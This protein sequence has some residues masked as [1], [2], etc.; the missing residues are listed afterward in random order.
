MAAGWRREPAPADPA[1]W[2]WAREPAAPDPTAS[3]WTWKPAETRDPVMSVL[4]SAPVPDEHPLPSVDPKHPRLE[5][6]LAV[7]APRWV[8]RRQAAR[9]ARYQHAVWNRITAANDARHRATD[10]PSRF[11]PSWRGSRFWHR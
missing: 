1:A 11:G 3:R 6:F 4:V 7:V 8:A 9:V 5:R 10:L 2:R